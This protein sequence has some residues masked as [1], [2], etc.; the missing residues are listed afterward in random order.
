MCQQGPNEVGSPPPHKIIKKQSLMI[1]LAF[2][3]FMLVL[4]SLGGS[5]NTQRHNMDTSGARLTLPNIRNSTFHGLRST[6]STRI[7][8]QLCCFVQSPLRTL[9]VTSI[10]YN[11]R[12]SKSCF[13]NTSNITG[14]LT[15]FPTS[16]GRFLFSFSSSYR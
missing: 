5:K 16:S 1:Y 10:F 15:S 2:W 13:P 3:C 9:F 7:D 4:R 6:L 11:Q 8:S 14:T 12:I